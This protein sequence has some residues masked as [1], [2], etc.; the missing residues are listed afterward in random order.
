VLGGYYAATV[1]YSFV[2][3][4]LPM[5]DVLVLAGLYT[6]RVMAGSEAYQVPVSRWLLAFSLFLFLSLAF[7]KRY[8]EV[9]ALRKKGVEEVQGRGYRSG[10][11]EL[12]SSTGSAAGYIAALVLA[13]YIQ[14]PDVSRLYAHPARL[15]AML[16][17]V[18]YWVSRVWLLAHRGQMHDDP[19]VFAVR[20]KVSYV[21]AALMVV[22]GF[23]AV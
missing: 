22:V 23:S 10:D 12:L 4:R 3:K 9:F 20:D 15:W 1:A 11:L 2:L 19:I 18:L 16:P 21:I 13:L 8:S 7:V 17:L 14:S 5:I 6:T